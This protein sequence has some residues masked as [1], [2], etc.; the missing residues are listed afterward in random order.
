MLY[1]IDKHLPTITSWVMGVRVTLI[2]E[3]LAH[4]LRIKDEGKL[5]TVDSN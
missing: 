5:I 4:I 1:K 3:S 2:K